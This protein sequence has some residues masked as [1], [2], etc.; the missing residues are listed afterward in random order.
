M[1]I[2]KRFALLSFLIIIPFISY[3]DNKKKDDKK[4]KEFVVDTVRSNSFV[5]QG[6]SLA[7]LKDY[8]NASSMYEQ[9][10][11]FNPKNQNAYFKYAKLYS[12][13]NPQSS[14]ETLQKLLV[15]DSTA[16]I[17]NKEIAELYYNMQDIPNATKY[18][19]LYVESSNPNSDDIARYSTI[20]FSN[21][22]YEKSL[23]YVRTYL[24]KDANHFVLRRLRMYNEFEL[25][26]TNSYNSAEKFMNESDTSKYI[27]YDYVYY[28][29]ILTDKKDYAKSIISLEKA[30]KLD[31]NSVDLYKNVASNYESLNNYEKA[32]DNYL[33][34][35]QKGKIQLSDYLILGQAYYFAGNNVPVQQD[36]IKRIGYLQKADSMF[37]IIVEKIPNNAIG[38]FWRARANSSIDIET[39]LG[40]AKP[41]YEAA[42]AI[43]E[44]DKKDKKK[45]I[46]SY[47][48]LGYYY[49]V[50]NEMATSKEYWNK[51]LEIDP[52]NETATKALKGIK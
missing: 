42:L 29:K 19:A 52:T 40:L 44:Q 45:I 4:S 43:L 46:E 38:Y 11:Y 18:Y 17:A 49:F 25:K 27:F 1:K 8:G 30:L 28:S 10:I 34:F 3:C 32:I 14:I 37:A 24:E 2:S 12:T 31:S 20:L 5:L 16:S 47:S 26:D 41:H 15:V 13:I 36:S 9:A 39:T 23:Q 33:M 35:F 22:N 21:K 50:K 6:D 7:L 48:Y 51:I